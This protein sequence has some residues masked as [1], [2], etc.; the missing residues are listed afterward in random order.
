MS[1]ADGGGMFQHWERLHEYVFLRGRVD[2]FRSRDRA[3]G[4]YVSEHRRQ[5]TQRDV[6]HCLTAL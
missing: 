5:F 4:A 6:V 1:G 2:H 3:S